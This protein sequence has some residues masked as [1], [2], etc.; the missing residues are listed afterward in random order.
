MGKIRTLLNRLKKSKDGRTLVA[1]FGYLSLLQVAGYVF[2]LITMPYLAR[3]IGVEGF[4]KIAFAAAI[5]GWI[6]TIVDWGFTSTATRD[7]A[8]KRDNIN[9][10]SEIFSNVFFSRILLMCVSFVILFFLIIFVPKFYELKDVILSTALMIP[11]YILFS[12]WFF[13]SVEKMKFTTIFNVL[14][15]MIFTLSVFFFI[16]KQEDYVL[17]PLILSLG[18]LITGCVSL[19]IILV[20]FRVKLFWTSWKKIFVS[21]K[22]STD[23]FLSNIIP[24]TYENIMIVFLGMKFGDF[25][26]GILNAA[27]KFT[28]LAITFI[29]I[30]SRTFFPFLSR[31][32]EK[33]FIFA[34]ISLVVSVCMA[35][36]LFAFAPVLID[37]FYG[38]KFINAVFVLR[39]LSVTVVLQT[40]INVYGTNFLLIIG[41]E[42]ILRNII[43]FSVLIGLLL[44]YFLI[45]HYGVLGTAIVILIVNGFIGVMAFVYSRMYMKK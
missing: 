18:Y 37:V 4:G 10:M 42:S 34:K 24:S 12:D 22:N 39:L 31:K 15:K 44:G 29:R 19:Y 30:L 28:N 33:H 40:L 11:G 14:I 13:Q 9:D 45:S 36:I 6:Q 5:I 21:I 20:K 32:I 43:F 26:N 3:V 25:A 27:T 16:K 2:P 1:N 38:D 7:L 17:Q 23:V 35:L 8:R 41:K